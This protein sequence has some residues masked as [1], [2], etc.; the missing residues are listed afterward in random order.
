ME[1]I[2]EYCITLNA[3]IL[4]AEHADFTYFSPTQSKS[5][6]HLLLM[7]FRLCSSSKC[8]PVEGAAEVVRGEQDAPLIMLS[9]LY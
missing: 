1:R 8:S 6:S 3:G 2:C 7:F 4:T 5:L 9:M